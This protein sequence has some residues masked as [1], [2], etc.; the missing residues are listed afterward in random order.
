MYLPLSHAT[1][2]PVLGPVY[3]LLHEH[4]STPALPNGEEANAGQARQEAGSGGTERYVLEEQ[5][6]QLCAPA[7]GVYCLAGQLTHGLLPVDDLKVP[8]AQATHGPSGGPLYPLL[9]AHCAIDELPAADEDH[10]GH[11]T[12]VVPFR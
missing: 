5:E 9:H 7:D 10:C 11:A 3:P 12:H 1:H 4:A 8:S 2:G 6:L